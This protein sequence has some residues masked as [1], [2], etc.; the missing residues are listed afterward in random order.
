MKRTNIAFLITLVI[1]LIAFLIMVKVQLENTA[2][3]GSKSLPVEFNVKAPEPKLEITKPKFEPLEYNTSRREYSRP[4]T[5]KIVKFDQKMDRRTA[6]R[7]IIVTDDTAKLPDVGVSTGDLKTG[8]SFSL[9]SGAMG[10]GANVRGGKSQL[11]E[12]VNKSRG[13]RK[14]VYCLDVSAS[15]GAGNKLNLARN[16]LKDSLFNLEEGKD[17]F[18]IITF[19]KD[20]RIFRP[21]DMVPMSRESLTEATDFLNQY[22]PQNITMNTKTDLLTPVLKAMELKPSIIALVTDGLPTAGVTNPEKI[23]QSIKEKNI[24]IKIFAI[25]ME[26]D[27]EQPEAWLMRAIAEQNNGE[28]QLF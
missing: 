26:M 4:N 5:I 6:Y 12:F 15:M 7:D 20:T 27:L 22:N 23:L 9:R 2:K 13:M 21:G 24:G 14:V 16:Y 3:V 1:H 18:N 8:G 10:A 11:V 28:F 25:G 17:M 19:S